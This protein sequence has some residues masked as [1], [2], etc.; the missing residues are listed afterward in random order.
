[1]NWINHKYVRV[2]I[3]SIVLLIILVYLKTH[4]FSN[5]DSLGDHDVTQVITT[6]VITKNL[7]ITIKEIG[8][9]VPYQTVAVKSRLDSQITEIMFKDGDEVKEN[10]ILFKLDDRN[11]KTQLIQSQANLEK[12]KA[13]LR[14]LKSQYERINKVAKAGFD[15]ASNLDQAQSAYEAQIAAVDATA[16]TIENI[17][18]QLDYCTI[19]SPISGKTGIIKVTLGNDVKANDTQPLVTINQIVPIKIQFSIPQKY[20]EK[21]QAAMKERKVEVRSEIAE[22]GR[23]TI[24]YIEYIDNSLDTTNDSVL[25]GAV[26]ANEDKSLWPGMYLNV[27]INLSEEKGAKVIPNVAVQNGQNDTKYVYIVQDNIA[28]KREVKTAEIVGDEVIIQDGLDIGAEVVID[29]M[30]KII[31]GSKIKISQG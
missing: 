1:M 15:T 20:F 16:A 8:Y 6:K 19:I 13:L 24:G 27:Y 28:H 3:I 17:K 29:G 25:V 5:S 10:Q 12:D 23:S 7:P 31:E 26:F 11:L 9:V 4:F 2:L 21:L 22:N 14:N 18:I 30:Q